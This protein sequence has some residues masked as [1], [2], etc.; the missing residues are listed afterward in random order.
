MDCK[1]KA[2]WSW[3]VAPLEPRALSGASESSSDRKGQQHW[4]EGH[5][6]QAAAATMPAA[7]EAEAAAAYVSSRR[8]EQQLRCQQLQTAAQQPQWK[9][10]LADSRGPDMP[11]AEIFLILFW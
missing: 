2:N 6:M 1:P 7:A 10:Q 8:R 3:R 9:V 4:L 5:E 11:I